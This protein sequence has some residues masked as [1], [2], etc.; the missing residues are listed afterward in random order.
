MY[1]FI[2]LVVIYSL[3]ID[4]DNDGI[5]YYEIIANNIKKLRISKKLSQEAMAEKL[6]CS[7]EFISRVENKREKVSLNML[8][9]I[10]DLFKVNPSSLFIKS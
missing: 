8:L 10:A 9:K 7:R 1:C 4:M 3:N 5:K 2:V 6:S